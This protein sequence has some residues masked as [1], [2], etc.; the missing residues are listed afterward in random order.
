MT[1]ASDMS[2]LEC[3]PIT[4]VLPSPGALA[5]KA[6][7]CSGRCSAHEFLT[8]CFGC[9][10]NQ[11][12]FPG[13]RASRSWWLALAAVG[14]QAASMAW[15]H[16]EVL[17]SRAQANPLK[18]TVIGQPFSGELWR[19]EE[20]LPDNSVTCVLQTSDGFLWI[21]TKH[22]LARFDGMRFELVPLIGAAATERP[23][24]TSLCEG[25]QKNLWIGTQSGLFAARLAPGLQGLSAS[26]AV[27]LL[28]IVCLTCDWAGR[29]WAGTP[30]GL[31]CLDGSRLVTYTKQDG[32]PNDNIR[33]LY[34]S[35]RKTLCVTTAVGFCEW[36]DGQF[37]AFAE[38][39]FRDPREIAG[40]SHESGSH[41]GAWP[42]ARTLKWR[43]GGAIVSRGSGGVRENR[44]P[45][46]AGKLVAQFGPCTCPDGQFERCHTGTRPRKCLAH[47]CRYA[48]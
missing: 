29:I 26:N 6:S 18:V 8:G 37:R 2:R 40:Q 11:V 48:R 19:T 39:G 41:P 34:V 3:R 38:A 35:R 5:E 23:R 47:E 20:G 1:F 15:A 13:R 28:N 17:D 16:E 10:M 22:G 43:R 45:A 21:G 31:S 14:I 25:V 24:I 42:R 12:T 27:P 4:D 30:T 33:Q 36:S 7:P 46:R 44:R 32:L 9:T